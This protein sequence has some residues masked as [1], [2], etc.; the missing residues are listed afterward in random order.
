MQQKISSDLL[1]YE[2][3]TVGETVPFGRKRVTKDEIIAFARA[4]DP[5]LIH[6]DEEVAKQSIVGGLCASGFHSCAIMMR[7]L[8]DDVL[9]KAT[10]LGSPGGG[11]ANAVDL[12]AG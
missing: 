2:D 11:P 12:E 6:L 5:Q 3:L 1:H 9:N 8:A 4:Y 7:M 10:S